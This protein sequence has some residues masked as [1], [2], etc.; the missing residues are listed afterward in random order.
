MTPRTLDS[1]G[2]PLVTLTKRM[3]D[4]TAADRLDFI[5]IQARE[6][7]NQPI[8]YRLAGSLWE[9]KEAPPSSKGVYRGDLQK[10]LVFHLPRAAMV[11]EVRALLEE[12]RSAVYSQGIP[13][14]RAA[15]KR[16]GQ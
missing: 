10:A 6:A 15:V 9:W 13:A 11:A 3:P 4:E 12:V 16:L 7:D 8:R 2:F 14:V 1:A 5:E